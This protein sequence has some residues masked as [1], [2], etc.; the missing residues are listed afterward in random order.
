MSGQKE[1][2]GSFIPDLDLK[3]LEIITPY[4]GIVEEVSSG[5]G[6]NS[7]MVQS[8]GVNGPQ[9]N[10][11]GPVVN[12]NNSH[13][14][15]TTTTEFTNHLNRLKIIS[16]DL[17]SLLELELNYEKNLKNEN[18]K[19]RTEKNEKLKIKR[20][21]DPSIPVSVPEGLGSD[22]DLAK[23]WVEMLGTLD[24]TFLIS[25]TVNNSINQINGIN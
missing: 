14:N 15:N 16:D 23:Q 20:T 8:P 13:G 3:S 9:G 7:P 11:P 12:G 18:E 17:Y 25:E 1:V 5:S 19:N 21:L 2:C 4:N 10:V 22:F 6:L 24:P